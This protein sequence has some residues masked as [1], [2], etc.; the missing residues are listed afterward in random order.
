MLAHE[1]NQPLATIGNFARGIARMLEG[2]RTNPAPL[3]DAANE[4]SQQAERAAGVLQ[5]IRGF[6]RKQP[7]E[8]GTVD[9]AEVATESIALFR[10]MVP[11]A[12]A[13]E[14]AVHP[15]RVR[16]DRLQ[17]EQ[18]ILNLLKNAYDA[19]RSQPAGD[20]ARIR[21]ECGASDAQAR[22]AV[23]DNGTGLVGADRERLFEPFFTTKPEGLGLG[24]AISLRVIESH[25]GRLF[26][27]P[28]PGGRG[29]VVGFLL[30]REAAT[31]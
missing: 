21:V 28:A 31:A 7:A 2:G 10:G 8:R 17:L 18:V 23:T 27:D 30:P 6:A 9:L 29:L 12:P 14:I 24:L 11:D 1:L 26:A 20:P 16:A 19:T 4:I 3:V 22:L 25:G 15:T 13:V 5:R